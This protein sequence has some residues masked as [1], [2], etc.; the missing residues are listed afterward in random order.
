MKNVSQ[1]TG[2]SPEVV[3]L[4]PQVRLTDR[5]KVSG[6]WI[7]ALSIFLA[8]ILIDFDNSGYGYRAWDL[9]YFISN[10]NYDFSRQDVLARDART[11][12]NRS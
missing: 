8:V 9:L 6:T 10:W 3:R 1:P 2:S 4:K 11:K 12:T 5:L 7:S